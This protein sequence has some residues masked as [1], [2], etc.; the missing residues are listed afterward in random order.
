MEV[1]KSIA[2]PAR[3]PGDLSVEK[4]SQFSDQLLEK[5]H[6]DNDTVLKE[7]GSQ[8][9]GLSTEEANSRT[10]QYGFNEIAREKRQSVLM[11]LLN[12]IKNP[13]VILL[14]ALGVI[15]FLTG[16]LRAMVVIF[17]MVLLGVVLRFFQELRADDAAEKLKAMVSTTATV[18]RQDKEEEVALKFL[19][20]GDIIRLA[21]GDMTPA[22]VRVLS[23]K[24]LFVNQAALTGE[25]MPV[26]KKAGLAPTDVQNP[27][28]LPNICFLGSNVES[29]S[30][31]AAVIHTGDQT[32]FGS[33]AA[34]IVGE[35]Q[36]TGFDKGI[37]KFTWLMIRFIAIM[38]PAVF[39]INGFS[40]HNWL[41]A[42]LFAMAVAVGLTPEM[43]PMIVT[44]NL[45]KGALAMSKKKV[46]VKRLN[47]IQ[48][49]GAMDVLCTDKT[50][51]IT[52]GK[53]VLEKYLDINGNSSD[54]VLQYGYLN[55]YHHTGLKNL[56]DEAVLSHEELEPASKAQEKYRKIDEIPFDFVRRRMS[57]IVEDK[58]GLNTLICKGAVEEVMSLC[59]RVD[60]DGKVIDMLP[61]FHDKG[62]KIANDLN[63]QGFRVIALAYKEM[64]GA[65]D[66]PTYAVKDESDLIL[67]GFLSFLDP[68]KDTATQALKKLHDLKVDVKILTGDNEIIT[69]Y[70][71]KE[72]GI[73][74][75]KILLGPQIEAMSE[76]ELDKAMD[77]ASVFAKLAPAHKEH[78]IHA[79]QRKGH[80]VGFMGDGINDA[81]ALKAADVGISVDSAVDIAKESSDIILL[82]NSLLILE[83][84]VLEGRRVFGNIIKY[85]KMA[86]SSNFGNM[87][88]VV[89]AS[90]F[91]PFLPMLPIQVLTN[92]LLY[93]FSQ[94][95][96]PTDEVDADWLAKPRKWTIGEIQRFILFIGPIS[97][98][99]DYLT[100]FIMLYVFN[101]WNNP[102][103]FHTGWFVE[104]LFTQTLIIHVI[105]T[106]KIPF[107]ESRASWP[108][109]ATSLIIVAVGAWLTI[110]PLAS[111]L[112]FVTLPP[113][114]WLLLAVMLV[115]YVV[116]TQLVKTW[117]FHKFGE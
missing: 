14:T 108:L 54:K 8:L 104:S 17:V 98:I 73:P 18:V 96:I 44:V 56:L 16:D 58:T 80:V 107:I 60:A 68:P 31:T 25:S 6:A 23:A 33:L 2:H 65:P 88:S 81:P 67:L 27:L 95:T 51:T 90:A 34:S 41:E 74:I 101:S 50:G 12:N 87:F 106:N 115:C 21:A 3:Q 36:L 39:L 5:A 66:E 13:L 79:L 19:V 86:A 111:T 55:S 28:E 1:P 77:S 10:K 59:S 11:R 32:Y 20:P 57:V 94:T 105:R 112:G 102:A 7:L 75:E 91:L 40:K 53:I 89:G 30:A 48:N 82:E 116:L 63:G 117:F 110:S 97:S 46:I 26:E 71:C 35:R 92:N 29:G 15:S 83:Q 69:A 64:P 84:G 37:N 114:Y 70:I 4:K 9:S 103:L 113:L 62:L 24:D 99:F 93:D 43:L 109:I 52:Q 49:F 85:I 76:A 61:E 78:I 45:S 100:F 22:D 42:F 38:V 72:V 47:S